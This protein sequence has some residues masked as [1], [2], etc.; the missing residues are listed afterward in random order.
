MT[1]YFKLSSLSKRLILKSV[2]AYVIFILFYF[3]YPYPAYLIYFFAGMIYFYFL[4]QSLENEQSI[5]RKFRLYLF[6]LSGTLSYLI[7]LVI[8]YKLQI[9]FINLLI[10]SF[11]FTIMYFLIIN[12]FYELKLKIFIL[13]KKSLFVSVISTVPYVAVFFNSSFS[14]VLFI[15]YSL[16]YLIWICFVSVINADIFIINES[17]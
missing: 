3:L 16:C 15:S 10:S 9:D 11:T 7:A 5:K 17:E 2:L 14:L 12:Y 1:E 6:L 13:L 8:F 4:N